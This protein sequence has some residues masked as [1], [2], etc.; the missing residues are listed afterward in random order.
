MIIVK[1]QN[2]LALQIIRHNNKEI[3]TPVIE[4][5]ENEKTLLKV[6]VILLEII[7]VTAILVYVFY[8]VAHFSDDWGT[9][10]GR[11]WRIGMERES[12]TRRGSTRATTA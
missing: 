4:T 3:I 10:R 8:T 1:E 9:M 5:E 2:I 11:T 12:A 7:L 6:L